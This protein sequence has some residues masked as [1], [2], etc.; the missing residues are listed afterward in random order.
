VTVHGWKLKLKNRP[1]GEDG[2]AKGVR[3]D[4]QVIA[5]KGGK[6]LASLVMIKKHMGI[7]REEKAV[8]SEETKEDVAM[9]EVDEEP[10]EG[11]EAKEGEEAEEGEEA[12]PEEEEEDE[13][14]EEEEDENEEEEAGDESDAESDGDKDEA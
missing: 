9:E 4:I 3:F 8:A 13:E 14:E 5:P 11:E 1:K 7:L 12:A 10:Q 2:K 6:K